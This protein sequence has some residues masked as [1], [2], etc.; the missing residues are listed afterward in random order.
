MIRQC[1]HCGK[2]F[3]AKPCQTICS[4]KCRRER[5]NIQALTSKNRHR[6]EINRRIRK[7]Y[8]A[9]KK[10]ETKLNE[11]K[12]TADEYSKQR[13]KDQVTA[14]KLGI[15]YGQFIAWLQAGLIAREEVN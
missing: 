12:L 14:R 11:K 5:Q 6:E 1:V 9:Q 2:E 15:S 4:D 3:E 8:H 10:F 7:R 13:R